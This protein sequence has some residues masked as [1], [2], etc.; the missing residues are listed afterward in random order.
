MYG[1][2]VSEE[3]HIYIYIYSILYAIWLLWQP[4]KFGFASTCC[5]PMS[6]NRNSFQHLLFLIKRKTQDTCVLVNI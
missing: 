1:D 2:E 3:E 5:F 6:G 4:G